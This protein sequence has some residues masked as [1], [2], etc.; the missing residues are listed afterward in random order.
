MQA[1]PELGALRQELKLAGVFRHRELRGWLKLAF[2]LGVVAGCLVGIVHYGWIGAL[3]L[4]TALYGNRA[5][6]DMD[7]VRALREGRARDRLA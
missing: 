5:W 4:A 3:F 2:L 7:P 6:R 1:V